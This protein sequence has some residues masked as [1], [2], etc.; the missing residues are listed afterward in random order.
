MQVIE[1]QNRESRTVTY[2]VIASKFYLDVFALDIGGGV[3]AVVH[4]KKIK[5]QASTIC[6]NLEEPSTF[7][8]ATKNQISFATIDTS[9]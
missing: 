5:V 3:P 2:V 7:Y 1:V 4:L 8:I 6:S 9:T